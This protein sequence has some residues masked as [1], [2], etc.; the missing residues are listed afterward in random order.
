[1]LELVLMLSRKDLLVYMTLLERGRIA[2]YEIKKAI[3]D[4]PESTTVSQSLRRLRELGLV[5]F[6]ELGHKF[7]FYTAIKPGGLEWKTLFT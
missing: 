1:M 6:V 5:D 3:G 7:R 2:V 4:P